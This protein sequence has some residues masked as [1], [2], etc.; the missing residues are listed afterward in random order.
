MI[1]SGEGI[2]IA[3]DTF[4]AASRRNEQKT[5]PSSL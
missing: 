4:N 5:R 2:L 3:H 1:Y